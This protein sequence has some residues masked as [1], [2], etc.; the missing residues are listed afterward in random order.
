LKPIVQALLVADHVYTDKATNKKIVA[1]IF[2][3]L[4]FR[5]P[6]DVPRPPD[7]P[8]L[9]TQPGEAKGTISV[10]PGGYNAGSPFCYIS[11][12]EV[13]GKQP[14][15]LRYIDLSSDQVI[16]GTKFGI[17]CN[18][19]L[20]TIEMVLPLPP[21]PAVKAATYTLELFWND[22]ALGAHRIT[23]AESKEQA[24]ES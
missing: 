17:E 14:F 24:P 8:A 21:L 11:L 22:E 4:W 10:P 19:P 5:K 7:D 20:Q 1:G 2:H 9:G 23:V 3:R 18:D 12:T 15:E 13:H 16:F 6:G